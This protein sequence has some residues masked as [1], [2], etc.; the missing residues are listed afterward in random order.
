[1]RNFTSRIDSL[2]FVAPKTKNTKCN[3]EYYKNCFAWRTKKVSNFKRFPGKQNS[4]TQDY[5]Q[6]SV[7]S[8]YSHAIFEV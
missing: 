8:V 7:F 5:S 6:D 3:Q 1:M 2:Y 4:F